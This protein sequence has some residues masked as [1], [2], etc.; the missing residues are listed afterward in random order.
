[1]SIN[2]TLSRVSAFR[3]AANQ[4]DQYTDYPKTSQQ[5]NGKQGGKSD[6]VPG[7]GSWDMFSSA[8]LAQLPK[9]SVHPAGK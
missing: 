4:A 1:M 2:S 8:Y 5:Y 7:C 6:N 3:L 9:M